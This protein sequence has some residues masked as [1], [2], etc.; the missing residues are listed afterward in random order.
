MQQSRS[1][2]FSYVWRKGSQEQKRNIKQWRTKAIIFQLEMRHSMLGCFSL[3]DDEADAELELFQTFLLGLSGLDVLDFLPESFDESGGCRLCF[4]RKVM[5][6]YW[7]FRWIIAEGRVGAVAWAV[8]QRFGVT[9]RWFETTIS[10]IWWLLSS[11]I[12]RL[13][14]LLVQKEFR[15]G[16]KVLSRNRDE[17]T[18]DTCKGANANE[19]YP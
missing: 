4:W 19:N 9:L 14:E 10:R 11:L 15:M 16:V 6:W 3:S 7:R 18:Q 13:I 17:S 5:F 12:F 8:L 1:L 2:C